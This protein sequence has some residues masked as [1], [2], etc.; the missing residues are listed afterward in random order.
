MGKVSKELDLLLT[1]LITEELG[2][3][4]MEGI[5]YI[6]AL[7]DKDTEL[8]KRCMA[9][10][11]EAQKCGFNPDDIIKCYKVA[12]GAIFDIKLPIVAD[13]SGKWGSVLNTGV[14][15]KS[16]IMEMATERR[17]KDIAALA[18]KCEKSVKDDKA[19]V[20]VA[21]Y[22]RN[23]V[24]KIVIGAKD[25]NGNDI[26]CEYDAYAIRHWDITAV[27]EKY[28]LQKG[29]KV[30]KIMPCEI[31]PSKTGVRFMLQVVKL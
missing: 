1:Q 11:E 23:V 16:K 29:Y 27:N 25:K 28:L 30:A 9:A 8:I 21:L 19:G 31:L 15:I 4:T 5:T 7:K 2:S 26:T 3:K 13:I 20:E 22:S 17:N 18:K 10:R 14:E 12:N 24:P 6:L